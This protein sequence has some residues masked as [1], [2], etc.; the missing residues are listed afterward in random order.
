MVVRR[1]LDACGPAHRPGHEPAAAPASAG[2][3]SCPCLPS[4][5][6]ESP[7]TGRRLSRTPPR[8]GCSSTGPRPPSRRSVARRPGARRRR[9]V[10]TA[11]RVA[12]GHRARRSP[13]EAAQPRPHH[14]RAAGRTSTCC[15]RARMPV[16]ERQRAMTTAILWSYDRLTPAAR[17]VCDRLALFERGFTVGAA[18]EAICPD[19]PEVIEALAAIVDAR[20]V[21]ATWTAARRCGSWSS[22]PCVRSPASDCWL[23]PTW[24]AE[25]G[26]VGGVPHGTR[27]R[28]PGPAPPRSRRP[29]RTG[30]VRR[31]RRRRRRGGAVG[32][33][34]RLAVR[35]PSSCCSPAW[36]RGP[37]PAATTRSW[38]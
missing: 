7:T 29:P 2:S 1:L 20:L 13:G 19:V 9:G 17:L 26:A 21:G 27:R 5:C 36:T 33:G 31:R 38:A 12:V 6:R 25:P 18:I 22:A 37:R 30:A 15:P 11:R 14:R 3:A 35:R 24:S 4:W 23:V 10:C 32:T 8:S 16:P 34:R 28:G